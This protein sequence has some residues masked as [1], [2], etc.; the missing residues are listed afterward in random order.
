MS[1][2]DDE[3]PAAAV[4]ED[5]QDDDDEED[6]EKLQ[7]EIE[8]MEA[9]A[10]RITKETEDMEKGSGTSAAA[11]AAAPASGGASQ[12]KRDGYDDRERWRLDHCV[13]LFSKLTPSR[14][15][16]RC[17]IYVGQV[18]YSATPEELLA[19]FE[20][21]GTVERVTIVCDKVTGRPKGKLVWCDVEYVFIG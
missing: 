8:R 3:K 14:F 6:L 2:K 16:S 20:A 7:A 18:D 10:A 13:P 17:S 21:C 15:L 4:E 12:A 19:H 1:E 9:E 5:K 11:A